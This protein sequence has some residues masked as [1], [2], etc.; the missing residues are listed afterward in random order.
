VEQKQFN[1]MYDLYSKKL[2]NYALWLTRNKDATSDIIQV[3]FIKLWRQEKA[4]HHDREVEAWLYT[5]TR[6]ACMDFFRKC[7]RFTSFRLKFARETTLYT[8][9][10]KE[11]RS[12][13]DKLDILKEKERTILFLHFRTGY[14][15]NK[16]A[17]VID[18]NESAVRVTAFRALEKLRKKCAKEIV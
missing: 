16:I 12:V 15:Y 6:N 3:V 11:N 8:E 14:S 17:E 2:Y 5:V 7:S 13:W 18:M 9:E 10:P 1:E 4:F